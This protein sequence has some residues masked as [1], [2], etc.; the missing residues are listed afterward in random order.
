MSQLDIDT[1]NK[2]ILDLNLASYKK[3]N[4]RWFVDLH[5]KGKT[6]KPLKEKHDDLSIGKCF[7]Q[8]NPRSTTVK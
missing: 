2:C 3:V 6:I 7:F 5:V 4:S 8:K 1:E